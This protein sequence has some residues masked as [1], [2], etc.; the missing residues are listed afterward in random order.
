MISSV[1]PGRNNPISERVVYCRSEI[2]TASE[3]TTRTTAA[4]GSQQCQSRRPSSHDAAAAKTGTPKNS[5][6]MNDVKVAACRRSSPSATV[7]AAGAPESSVA[8]ILGVVAVAL[9]TVNVV[10]GFLVTNR[11]LA[12]FRPRKPSDS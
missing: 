6:T 10:G 1:A 2:V 3:A 11:M 9:A 12:M 7:S 4:A 8:S 5:V